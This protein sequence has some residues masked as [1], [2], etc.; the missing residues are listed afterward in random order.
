MYLVVWASL[1]VRETTHFCSLNFTLR[2]GRPGYPPTKPGEKNRS[3]YRKCAVAGSGIIGGAGR[4]F[5]G[6]LH[7]YLVPQR[8]TRRVLLGNPFEASMGK[9]SLPLHIVLQ[10]Y[11]EV[12]IG[13]VGLSRWSPSSP[14]STPWDDWDLF[15]VSW[16]IRA[17]HLEETTTRFLGIS[18][19]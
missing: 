7:Q 2:M 1:V 17:H 10:A 8:G 11:D 6:W 15:A 13:R 19:K 5:A 12:H 9:L 14:F 4:Y 18:A 3:T 16:T